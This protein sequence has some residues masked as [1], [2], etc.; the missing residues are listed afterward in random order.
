MATMNSKIAGVTFA[1]DPVDGGR[2]RQEILA[3]LYKN[4]R[5]ITVNLR[6]TTFN[7]PETGVV[8]PAIKCVERNTKQVIGYIP[9][10]DIEKMDGVRQL[11][12]FINFIRDGYSVEL[13]EQQAPSTDQ[14]ATAKRYCDQHQRPIPAYDSRALG[15][16]FAEM[17]GKR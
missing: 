16:V 8:E 13:T 4:G 6:R 12:G 5:I 7:N 15:Q 14:Y 9:R 3:E 11:T 1:N 2:N 17:R 10:T